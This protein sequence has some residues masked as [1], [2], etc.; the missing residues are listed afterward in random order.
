MSSYYDQKHYGGDNYGYTAGNYGYNPSYGLY[1]HGVTPQTCVQP[2]DPANVKVAL[3][4]LKCYS[5]VTMVLGLLAI[6]SGGTTL[7][8]AGANIGFPTFN[9]G[10][11][12]VGI[13]F[14]IGGS[15]GFNACRKV[16]NAEINPKTLAVARCGLVAVFAISVTC[17]SL[18]VVSGVFAIISGAL[19]A[20][21]NI[22]FHS[23]SGNIYRKID[24]K[25]Y[26]LPH[27]T[28]NAALG[29]LDGALCILIALWCIGGCILFCKYG[30][31]FGIRS[32]NNC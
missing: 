7:G 16:E 3:Q 17:I 23:R 8:V 31:F 1:P 27:E 20:G 24:V 15:V 25:Q 2:P 21:A 14:F 4:K 18:A 10:P 11:L 13:L 12:L 5:I 30:R 19:C 28:A 22:E 6:V 32:R 29:I 26:C 9:F